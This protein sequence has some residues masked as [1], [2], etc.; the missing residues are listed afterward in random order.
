MFFFGTLVPQ[1]GLRFT[2]FSITGIFKAVLYSM[3]GDLKKVAILN[4]KLIQPPEEKPSV[5]VNIGISLHLAI[6]CDILPNK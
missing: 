5:V 1:L 6:D 3:A 2:L 4:W